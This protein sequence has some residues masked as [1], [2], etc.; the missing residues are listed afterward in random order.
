MP[1]GRAAHLGGPA[2]S[3]KVGVVIVEYRKGF[4]CT[5]TEG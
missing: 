2:F 3:C 1:I 5:P 4:V